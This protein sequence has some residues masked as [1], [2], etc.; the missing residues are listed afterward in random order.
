MTPLEMHISVNQR[1][2]KIGLFVNDS[3]LEEEVDL[4]LNKGQDRFIKELVSNRFQ[5]KELRAAFIK[6]LLEKNKVIT[7]FKDDVD[8][9]SLY[10]VMP[11]DFTY[12]VND[13]S[14]TLKGALHPYCDNLGTIPTT[15]INESVAVLPYPVDTGATPFYVNTVITDISVAGP[16]SPVTLY[17]AAAPLNTFTSEEEKYVLINHIIETINAGTSGI[18]V[19]WERYRNT[20]YKQS[21]I[22]VADASKVRNGI[23]DKITFTNA[24]GPTD[25]AYVTTSY[26]V[27]DFTTLKATLGTYVEKQVPNR[28]LESEELYDNLANVYFKT[29]AVEPISNQAGDYLYI[30]YD[31]SFIVTKLVIDYI[32]KPRIIS[33]SLNQSCELPEIAHETIV[34]YTVEMMKLDIQDPTY[35]QNVADNELRNKK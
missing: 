28:N 11:P 10:G 26:D 22:F 14:F 19:Y 34:D 6:S 8:P 32:R 29:K 15:T 4:G 9:N 2:Q 20:Y 18:K 27:L 13:R 7:L 21:F 35:Q 24:D 16:G 30:F 17:T 3:Y 12:L 5:D 31:E 25:G 33:L 1:L 23:G